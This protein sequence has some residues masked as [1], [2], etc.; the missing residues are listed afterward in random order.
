MADDDVATQVRALRGE[1]ASTMDQ[2][3][4]TTLKAFCKDIP[5]VPASA[6][7]KLRRN[8]ST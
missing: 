5:M 6:K 3:N 7:P 1:L 4:D 8:L 2:K